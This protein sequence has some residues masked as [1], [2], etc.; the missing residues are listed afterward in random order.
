MRLHHSCAPNTQLEAHRAPAAASPAGPDGASAPRLLARLVAT[1]DILPG[2]ALT[3]S[4]IVHAEQPRRARHAQL[5]R[6]FGPATHCRCPRCV[7][8]SHPAAAAAALPVRALRALAEQAMQ[9]G[10]AALTR[11][12]ALYAAVAYRAEGGDVAAAVGG[13]GVG[14]GMGVKRRLGDGE[15]EG[16]GEGADGAGG[17]VEAL[18][19]AEKGDLYHALGAALLD[20]PRA[21]PSSSLTA[22]PASLTRW[23]DAHRVWALGA[24]RCPAHAALADQARKAAAYAQHRPPATPRAPAPAPS[25]A[26]TPA[27]APA[28]APVPAPATA[29]APAPAPAT[30]P[31]PAPAAAIAVDYH[32][33]AAEPSAGAGLRV[34]LSRR[35]V[36]A[37]EECAAA[38]R[39]AGAPCTAFFAFWCGFG[40][41]WAWTPISR[42]TPLC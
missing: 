7:Y 15:G 14:D 34:Y 32:S 39:W 20:C 16:A 23:P 9:E 4:A 29:P 25:P 30:A 1:R 17:D 26:P 42:A 27:P 35:P 19:E 18:T 38:V 2:E 5:T 22:P 13:P 36:L 31:A 21:P 41:W 11:A 24:A 37:P 3:A 28:S 33:A 10:G 6:R 40:V 12:V 8:D